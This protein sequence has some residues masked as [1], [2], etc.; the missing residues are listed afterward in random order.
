MS[1]KL[2]VVPLHLK[3][4]VSIKRS[5]IKKLSY[6]TMKYKESC[7]EYEFDEILDKI[8]TN[9]D[10]VKT[11]KDY[12]ILLVLKKRFFLREKVYFNGF[13][14]YYYKGKCYKSNELFDIIKPYLPEC[15]Q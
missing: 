3:T 13:G 11:A 2:Y 1:F 8:R 6:V 10:T 7:G 5:D 4:K 14:S 15:T 12:R 9:A